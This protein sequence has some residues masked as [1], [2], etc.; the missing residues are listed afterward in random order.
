MGRRSRASSKL[1]KARSRKARVSQ[2]HT[3]PAV[4]GSSSNGGRETKVARLTRELNEAREQQT[5]SAE[6]LAS[7]TAS[8]AYPKAQDYADFHS[9]ITAG[10]CGR[11][12]G[13]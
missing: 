10:I 5:A 6:I 8:I 9:R 13:V 2:R 3:A 7:I 12:N 4:R 11:P 1:A